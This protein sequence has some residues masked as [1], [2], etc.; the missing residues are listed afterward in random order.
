MFSDRISLSLTNREI[1]GSFTFE[2]G[3]I[4]NALKWL[5]KKCLTL[6]ILA[7]GSK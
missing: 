2:P 1:I 3:S 7:D 4:S 6:L 5:F